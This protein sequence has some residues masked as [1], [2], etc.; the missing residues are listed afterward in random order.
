M[1]GRKRKKEKKKR[2]IVFY[3]RMLARHAFLPC[4]FML[5]ML[6]WDGGWKCF[7]NRESSN[8]KKNKENPSKPKPVGGRLI[9]KIGPKN[10]NHSNKVR[11]VHPSIDRPPYNTTQHNTTRHDTTEPAWPR[12]KE[13]QEKLR[14]RD[15]LYSRPA[16]GNNPSQ[17]SVVHSPRYHRNASQGSSTSSCPVQWL[18]PP[19]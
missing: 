11:I 19:Y 10:S 5:V 9:D 12:G 6:L 7:E 16:T 2:M 8:E 17:E 15:M 4:P 3:K 14:T 18:P 13:E 1:R